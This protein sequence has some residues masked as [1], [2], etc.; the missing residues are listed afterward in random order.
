MR[1]RTFDMLMSSFGAVVTV[2][3]VLM[4]IL[5][6]VAANFAEDN[7]TDRLKPEKIFFPSEQALQQEGVTNE[8]ILSNAGEQVVDG[9]QA[10]AYADYINGHLQEVNGG[11]TYSETSSEARANPNDAALQAKVQT[12]FRGETL[13][14]ILLNAYGWWYVAQVVRWAGIGLLILAAIMLVLTIL[15]F[16]HLRRTPESAQL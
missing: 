5:A 6:L 2:A 10:K 15:G 3:L 12:L 11:K 16:V 9:S 1:R 8:E 13:R 4:G 7:V 14:A